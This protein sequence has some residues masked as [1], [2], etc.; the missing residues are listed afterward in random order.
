MFFNENLIYIVFKN[1]LSSTRK[2]DEYNAK[3]SNDSC[4][5][6]NLKI[7]RMRKMNRRVIAHL[8][9]LNKYC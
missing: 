3:S 2:A 4:L 1:G 9:L 8:I 7:S 6:Q 5:V